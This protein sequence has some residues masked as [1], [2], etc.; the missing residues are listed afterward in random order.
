MLSF[1]KK[2]LTVLN[3]VGI[4]IK[5]WDSYLQKRK[6]RKEALIEKE[7]ADAKETIKNISKANAARANTSHD[8]ELLNKYHKNNK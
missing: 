5:W 7:L 4:L 3:A 1:F 6:D 2:A 8:S